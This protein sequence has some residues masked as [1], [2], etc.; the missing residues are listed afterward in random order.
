MEQFIIQPS[1]LKAGKMVREFEGAKNL[2]EQTWIQMQRP[3]DLGNSELWLL[4]DPQEIVALP[5]DSTD[6]A[7]MLE[8]GIVVKP[9]LL[10]GEL[11]ELSAKALPRTKVRVF[12][13]AL[14]VTM[15]HEVAF[16]RIRALLLE[17]FSG[18]RVSGEDQAVEVTDIRIDGGGDTVHVAVGVKGH[19]DTTLHLVGKLGYDEETLSLL[20]SELGYTRSTMEA[21]FNLTNGAFRLDL[22]KLNAEIAEN[23]VF[24]LRSQ[25]QN[26]LRRLGLGL[27]SPLNEQMALSGG[28]VRFAALDTYFSETALCVRLVAVGKVAL[29]LN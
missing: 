12:G 7:M 11:P 13:P 4:F 6:G 19:I 26:T 10:T 24:D 9:R 28:A 8:V 16:E 22:E 2:I 1:L 14:N 23:L 21:I 5:I 27:N 3:M 20:V 15:D 25:H 29:N 18:Q 17:R